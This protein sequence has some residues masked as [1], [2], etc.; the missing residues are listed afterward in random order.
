MLAEAD[1][2]YMQRCIELALNAE[3]LTYPN[4][5]VGA[6]VVHDDVILGEGYHVYAGGPHAEV[7]AI[8]AVK[9]RELLPESTL[10]VSLEPCCHYGKT[11]PCTDLIISSGI[12]RVVVG[13]IDTSTKVSGRGV[14]ILR[15]AGKEVK[16]GVIENE[17]RWVNRRFFTY[18]ER[19]RPYITL[20]W[21]ESADGFIDIER[22]EG[23]PAGPYWITG[24]AE[25]VLV[26]KWRASEEA[27]LVGG[28]T[29]RKD[30]PRLN[31]R[32]WKG[33]DPVKIILSRSGNIGSYFSGKRADGGIIVFTG[34]RE[35]KP[36]GAEVVF[37]EENEPAALR[38]CKTLYD[39]GIQSLFIEGGAKVI[40]HFISEGLWDEA[41]I[42]RGRKYF[43]NGIKAPVAGGRVISE[44]LFESG[45]LEVLSND[46][47]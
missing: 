16:V 18:H 11:P 25:R 9:K 19:K 12:P 29:I 23:S 34:N 17:C 38:I 20:K 14:A 42:F 45:V 26:H 15:E 35:F 39:K 36:D 24:M 46:Y 7:V 1:H 30:N 41:R 44:T 31:V 4:P 37:L 8:N 28:E 5:M 40:Q 3:G 10:Y 33:K 32:Y 21:A 22:P 13:T 2:K 47:L 27:I 6:V 43:R